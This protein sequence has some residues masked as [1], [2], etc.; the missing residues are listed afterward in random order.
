MRLF[1]MLLLLLPGLAAGQAMHGFDFTWGDPVERTD[2]EALDPDEE[3]ASYRL[4]CVRTDGA[5]EAS[6]EVLRGDTEAVEGNTRGY[7]WEDAVERG[8]WYDC[9]ILA[10]D[11]EGLSSDWSNVASV[12]KR[13]Q[14]MPPGQLRER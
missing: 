10:T 13:A 12:R 2:G 4:H 6:I 1:L 9:R 11:T 3:V 5:E 8:G 7:F 14:P